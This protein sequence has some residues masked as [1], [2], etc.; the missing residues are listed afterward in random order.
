M[1]PV[2]SCHRPEEQWRAARIPAE[3]TIAIAVSQQDHRRT[4]GVGWWYSPWRSAMLYHYCT[5]TL[6]CTLRTVLTNKNFQQKL[7]TKK[8]W[9]I[10]RWNLCLFRF[11]SFPFNG[12]G[13]HIQNL[14]RQI[15]SEIM[16]G[17]YFLADFK[18]LKLAWCTLA[19]AAACIVSDAYVRRECAARWSAC[20]SERKNVSAREKVVRRSHH[21]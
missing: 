17:S 19:V 9:E 13:S 11:A 5:T 6:P 7:I 2:R 14:Q 16:I 3:Q 1:P 18:H 21:C 8:F 4:I 15:H 20:S 12:S 10:H